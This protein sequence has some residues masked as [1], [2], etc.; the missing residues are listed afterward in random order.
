MV[1]FVIC[2]SKTTGVSFKDLLRIFVVAF[3]LI[4]ENRYKI[5]DFTWISGLNDLRRFSAGK[6]QRREREKVNVRRVDR[7]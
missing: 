7:Y 4:P 6:I 2:D 1:K 3:I 5:K